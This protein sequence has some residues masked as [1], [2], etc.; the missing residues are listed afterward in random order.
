MKKST[1][2][3]IVAAVVIVVLGISVVRQHHYRSPDSSRMNQRVHAP[4]PPQQ[5]TEAAQAARDFLEAFGKEDWNAVAKYWPLDAPKGKRFDDFTD[6]MKNYMSGLEITSLGTPYKE[7]PNSWVLV[8]YEVRFKNGHTQTNSLR[9]GKDRDG[10]WH[11][12]GGF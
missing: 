9:M 11:F 2:I 6:Q 10:Q 3:I 7:G 8:P 4:P 1:V 5:A 12:E